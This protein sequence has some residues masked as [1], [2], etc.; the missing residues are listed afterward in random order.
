MDPI[1][2]IIRK[3]L[4]KCAFFG[5]WFWSSNLRVVMKKRLGSPSVIAVFSELIGQSRGFNQEMVE[6]G[7]FERI[8]ELEGPDLI[9]PKICFCASFFATFIP[10]A[11]HRLNLC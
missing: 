3:S 7:L 1:A 11:S 2:S 5:D 9:L 10:T 4:R 6:N 8:L